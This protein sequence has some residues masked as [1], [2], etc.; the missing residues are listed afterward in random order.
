MQFFKHLYL[1][2]HS[3]WL[4]IG[5]IK[6]HKLYWYIFIPAVIMLGIYKLGELIKDH[7]VS[8]ELNNMNEIIWYLTHVIIEISVAL[9]LMK[10]AK[11]LVVILLSPLLSHL[12]QKCDHILTGDSY[13]FSFRQLLHDVQRGVRIS[14]RNLMWEYL[15]FIIIYTVSVLG[16]QEPRSAPIF[17]LTFAIGFYFYGFNF[18]DYVNER[19][20]LDITQSV[21]FVR[22]HRGVAVAIGTIYSIL[23]LVPVEL[24]E[25]FSIFRVS[26]LTWSQFGTFLLHMLLWILAAIAPIWAIVAATIAMSKLHEDLR[27][28]N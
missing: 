26:E 5:F 23:I 11:Y 17:Y 28:Y 3:Y 25:L 16:W 22:Q 6:K 27:K 19:K 14:V 15:F 12:S 20:K 24:G 21:L 7:H 1:G 8:T 2:F 9:L 13:P 4:A 10:F 18:L